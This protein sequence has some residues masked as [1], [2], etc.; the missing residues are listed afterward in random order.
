[1]SFQVKYPLSLL[2]SD[3]LRT[4]IDEAARKRAAF[5]FGQGTGK[6]KDSGS[7]SLGAR[8]SPLSSS[9]LC[10]YFLIIKHAALSAEQPCTVSKSS[11]RSSGT[12]RGVIWPVLRCRSSSPALF[13][14]SGSRSRKTRPSQK[15]CC[16][17]LSS[18][19]RLYQHS[20]RVL[21][22]APHQ[23]RRYLHPNLPALRLMTRTP[24]M[25]R[26]TPANLSSR[27]KSKK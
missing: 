14:C 3:P 10:S 21:R 26:A 2:A 27:K 4:L 6:T 19:W 12:P 18:F 7:N 13:L 24:R 1:M 17:C 5:L 9:N 16:S 11:I 15:R 23:A 20:D 8:L 22:K 25:C